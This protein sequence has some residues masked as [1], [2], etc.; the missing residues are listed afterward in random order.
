[1]K[2]CQY[3]NGEEQCK[4]IA[5][6]HQTIARTPRATVEID[7]CLHCAAKV[8]RTFVVTTTPI[9][10]DDLL[11]ALVQPAWVRAVVE[12]LPTS[13]QIEAM[14]RGASAPTVEAAS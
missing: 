10:R 6:L 3:W 14:T 12:L 4:R 1:M 9:E 5:V 8:K 7:V 11:A 2:R 13:E